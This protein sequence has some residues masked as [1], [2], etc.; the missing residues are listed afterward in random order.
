MDDVED[1][2]YFTEFAL[3]M[4]RGAGKNGFISAISDFFTTPIHGIKNT[5]F[6][7]LRTVKNKQ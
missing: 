3:F 4:G 1:T 2:P 5:I 6:Q 7:L